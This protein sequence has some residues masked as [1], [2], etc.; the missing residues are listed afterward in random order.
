MYPKMAGFC[1]WPC[2]RRSSSSPCWSGCHTSIPY[3]P[4]IFGFGFSPHDEPVLF[5]DEPRTTLDES[6]DVVGSNCSNQRLFGEYTDRGFLWRR[7]WHWSQVTKSGCSEIWGC[8]CQLWVGYGFTVCHLAVIY[9]D[10]YAY[11]SQGAS[12]VLKD[13]TF[14]LRAVR[15]LA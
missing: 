2:D 13:L 8:N 14:S 5:I 10:N 1:S 9:T 11:C 7:S 3:K 4:W 6:R 15:K 12:P